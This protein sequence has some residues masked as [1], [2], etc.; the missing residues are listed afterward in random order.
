MALTYIF[1]ASA[2][3]AVAITAAGK[4]YT[5]NSAGIITAVAPADALTLSGFNGATLL[6]MAS[7][8]ATTDRPAPQPATAVAGGLNNVNPAPQVGDVFQDTTLTKAVYF[9]GTGRNSTG[10]VDINGAAV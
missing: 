10:W 8:G 1:A 7:T 2:P 3:G 6:P 5:A 9:V 4:Q